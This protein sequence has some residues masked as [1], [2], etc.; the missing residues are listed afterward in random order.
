MSWEARQYQ[1]STVNCPQNTCISPRRNF[2][3]S[4]SF[5]NMDTSKSHAILQLH[6]KYMAQKPQFLQQVK[7][8]VYFLRFMTRLCAHSTHIHSQKV[9]KHSLLRPE[10]NTV[11]FELSDNLMIG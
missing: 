2:P 10:G 6:C 7:L 4:Q 3:Y 1:M 8:C 9:S 11:N 5:P